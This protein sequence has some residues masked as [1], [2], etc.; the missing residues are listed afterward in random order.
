VLEK[1]ETKDEPTEKEAAKPT[2]EAKPKAK[3]PKGHN[4]WAHHQLEPAHNK[5]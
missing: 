3:T 1:A 5:S 2:A 4:L